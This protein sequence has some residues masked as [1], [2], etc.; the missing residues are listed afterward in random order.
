M[1]G[2]IEHAF[3]LEERAERDIERFHG[4]A[5]RPSDKYLW[6]IRA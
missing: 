3:G 4:I 5:K 2:L 1:T 6:P